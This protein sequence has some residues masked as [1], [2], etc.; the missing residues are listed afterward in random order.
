MTPLYDVILVGCGPVG[1]TV[2]NLLGGYGRSTLVV[3]KEIA[4][5]PQPRAIHFDD[6][7]MR[8]FQAIGLQREIAAATRPILGMHF[9]DRQGRLLLEVRKNAGDHPLY[10]FPPANVFY[11][12]ELE[13]ILHS[14]LARYP[15]VDLRLGL[16][17]ESFAQD[18]GGVVV[19]LRGEN[20]KSSTVRGRYLLGCDGASSLIRRQMGIGLTDLGLHQPWLVIDVR[21]PSSTDDLYFVRQICDPARPATFVPSVGDR[22]R[23]EFMLL[24]GESPTEMVRPERVR[25]LLAAHVADAVEIERAAVYTFHALLADRWR[26]NRVFL[27]GDAAH[28]MPPFLGQGMCAGIRDAHNLAWKLDRV[29]RG[30]APTALLDTYQ[31]ERR[32][33][34]AQIIHMARL[35]GGII[36]TRRRGSAILRDGL[37]R[38]AMAIPPVRRW[39]RQLETAVPGLQSG[40]FAPRNKAAGKLLPQPT[41]ESADGRIDLL[42]T[43]LGDDFALI[44]IGGAPQSDLGMP[45]LRLIGPRDPWPDAPNAI[46]DHNGQ[47]SAWMAAHRAEILIIRPDRYVFGG[48]GDWGLVTGD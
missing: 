20:G 42:D 19:T 26:D 3:E 13:T 14:G 17:A 21:Q 43:F 11:Q 48:F 23:W 16:A 38:A 9:V 31:S 33:H 39:L 37:L 25:A 24:P 15:H 18:E 47:L 27:L 4:I 36:Q 12:P 5:H 46:R 29:L 41:V 44:H 2:A 34:V 32:P 22:R 28:Q 40:Y 35:A 30:I 8:I 1:A 7:T 6:E 45:M 10:G